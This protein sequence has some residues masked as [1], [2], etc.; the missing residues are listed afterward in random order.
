MES[1]EIL[2]GR[3]RSMVL[4]NARLETLGGQCRWLEGPVWFA[5]HEC[6]YV[7]DVPND[8]VLRWSEA[9]GMSVFRQPSGF[10]NGHARD[11]AGRLL[12]CS[13]RHRCI[14][15]TEFDGTLT[16]LASHYRGKRLSSP[17]DI[18]VRP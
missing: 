13:H 2:D 6:L 12:G 16:V 5:D 14:T 9:G 17:N 10:A 3:F 18:V 8:R 11:R 15:R 1:L 7:S 4:D